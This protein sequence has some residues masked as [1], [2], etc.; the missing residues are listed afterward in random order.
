[1]NVYVSIWSSKVEQRLTCCP[2]LAAKKRWAQAHAPP[3]TPPCVSLE[4]QAFRRFHDANGLPDWKDGEHH[5]APVPYNEAERLA[6]L[7]SL[8]ILDTGDDDAFERIT[9]MASKLFNVP[10]CLVSLVDADRQYFKSKRGLVA[11]ETS[12]DMAF[13]AYAVLPDAPDVFVVP[14]AT[15]DRRFMFNVLVTGPPDLRFYAGAPLILDGGLKI[16]TLCLLDTV[17]HDSNSFSAADMMNL[18]DLA[19]MVVV[20]LKL[21]KR[22]KQS[23]LGYIT[24][25]AH[26]LQTPLACFE[27]SLQLLKE[28][29]LSVEHADV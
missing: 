9:K 23:Q 10:I 11:R 29:S 2:L 16:G 19:Q 20:E 15:T 24:A 3:V 14:D 22:L 1:M 13:C 18:V 17:P 5:A 21:R 12:R 27:L 6:L 4:E 25:T 26:N 28:T 7:H 8:Q